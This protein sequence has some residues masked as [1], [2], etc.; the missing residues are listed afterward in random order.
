MFADDTILYRENPKEYTENLLELVNEFSKVTGYTTNIQKSV[1]F[2][3]TNYKLSE[4][5]I[6]NPIYDFI[7][8]SKLPKNKFNQGGKRLVLEKL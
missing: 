4:R 6:K 2:L 7:K 5:E 3:Y 1:A 8:N